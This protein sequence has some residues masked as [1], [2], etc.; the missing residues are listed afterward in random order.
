[1]NRTDV[2]L[3]LR[4]RQTSDQANGPWRVHCCGRSSLAPCGD[5]LG[6]HIIGVEDLPKK[7]FSYTSSSCIDQVQ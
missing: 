3:A 2:S 7:H 4:G 1:M 5:I 6:H